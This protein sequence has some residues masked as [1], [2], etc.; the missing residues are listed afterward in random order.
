MARRTFRTKHISWRHWLVIFGAALALS[1][2]WKGLVMGPVTPPPPTNVVWSIPLN[3]APDHRCPVSTAPDQFGGCGPVPLATPAPG[4]HQIVLYYD[5]ACR[6]GT[7][8]TG[9]H[10]Q[11]SQWLLGETGHYTRLSQTITLTKCQGTITS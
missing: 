8:S 6:S 1:G 11:A 2:I 7:S 10:L 5:I 3:H 9:T 4:V